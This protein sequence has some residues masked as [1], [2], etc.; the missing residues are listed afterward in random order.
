MSLSLF[1]SYFT[2]GAPSVSSGF[3][4]SPTVEPLSFSWYLLMGGI[5]LGLG[6]GSGGLVGFGG[7][8]FITSFGGSF[9]CRG[10]GTGLGLEFK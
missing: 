3:S 10:Q 1:G 4:T 5:G 6:G 9:G 7:I 2:F 8:R